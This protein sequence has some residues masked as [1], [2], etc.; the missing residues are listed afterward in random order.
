MKKRFFLSIALLLAL[1]LLFGCSS[2]SK[3]MKA[4]PQAFT[5]SSHGK[6]E[7]RLSGSYEE[8]PATNMI[9]MMSNAS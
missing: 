1:A 4:S 7:D 3:D 5:T 9:L 8:F 2:A 6:G